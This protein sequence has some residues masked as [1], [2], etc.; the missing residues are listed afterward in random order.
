MSKIS[1]HLELVFDLVKEI[2][3]N[4]YSVSTLDRGFRFFLVRAQKGYRKYEQNVFDL[5]QR[6]LVFKK[7]F[8]TSDSN[9]LMF[10]FRYN[11]LILAKRNTRR[12]IELFTFTG[13]P[14]LENAL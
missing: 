12:Q 13:I 2:L 11:E 8:K 7:S 1:E 4:I 3:P 14:I 9:L 10:H 6:E 5:V